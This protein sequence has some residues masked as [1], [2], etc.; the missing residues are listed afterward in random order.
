MDD[1]PQPPP[2]TT[3]APNVGDPKG[4]LCIG[5]YIIE[6]IDR[7]LVEM[8][9][10]VIVFYSHLITMM[11]TAGHS[12]QLIRKERYDQIKEVL[13]RIRS[14]EAVS[15]IRQDHPQCYKWS[16]AYALV[17]DGEGGV[18][19]VI[20]PKDVAGFEALQEDT[21]IDTILHLSYFDKSLCRH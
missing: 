1:R 7:V 4:P 18:I 8:Q 3:D 9:E 11:N 6:G 17:N 19:V 15:H 21:D 5:E 12:W 10:D 20:H 14:G 16:S 13:V 2:P